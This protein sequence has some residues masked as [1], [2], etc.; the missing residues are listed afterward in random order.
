MYRKNALEGKGLK[1][2][3][4]LSIFVLITSCMQGEQ[5]LPV[6]QGATTGLV[7]PSQTSVGC[8]DPSP[9][10]P[11]VTFPS[12]GTT[13]PF[14]RITPPV[15]LRISVSN[16]NNLPY[17]QVWIV[18]GSVQATNT[19]SFI[20]DSSNTTLYPTLGLQVV[21]SAL[22]DSGGN[23][24]S[25]L[26]WSFNILSG[27][28]AY[29]SLSPLPAPNLYPGSPI[30]NWNTPQTI[31]AVV[32]NPGG[33]PYDY[34]WFLDGV[35]VFAGTNWNG[36]TF[37]YTFTPSTLALGLHTVTSL[38]TQSGTASAT[39]ATAAWSF[40][41]SN[42][43]QFT[44]FTGQQPAPAF[45]PPVPFGM[46]APSIITLAPNQLFN[47]LN[48][49]FT[50]EWTLD[51]AID[52]S[53]TYVNPAGTNGV[54]TPYIIDG[55]NRT[56]F[57]FG[58]HTVVAI[59]KDPTNA[60]IGSAAWGFTI[61]FPIPT[62]LTASIPCY[63]T[64]TTDLSCITNGLTAVSSIPLNSTIPGFF[65]LPS[66]PNSRGTAL[67][68]GTS[69]FC[70]GVANGEGIGF[71]WDPTLSGVQVQFR[72]SGGNPITPQPMEFQQ[73][74]APPNVCLDGTG[75]R[76]PLGGA[77]T[78]SL[79]LTP[80]DALNTSVSSFI[81]AR[82][83]DKL[84]LQVVA[85]LRWDITITSLNTAPVISIVSPATST[86]TIVQDATTTF[87]F[88]VTDMD[89]TAVTNFS[90]A[91]SFTSPLGAAIPL[92]G[93]NTYYPAGPP[94]PISPNCVR[95]YSY[96][97]GDKFK[98]AIIIPSNNGS[99]PVSAT[100]TYRVSADVNNLS[101]YPFGTPVSS[102][103]TNL[104][105]P[106]IPGNI[107]TWN[108]NVV[109]ANTGGPYLQNIVYSGAATPTSNSYMYLV[110]PL[111]TAVAASSASETNSIG[112]NLFVNDP[113]KDNYIVSISHNTSASPTEFTEYY[114]STPTVFTISGGAI[115]V[116]SYYLNEDV[117]SGAAF[118]TI[119][120][121]VTLTD[122]PESASPL[123][124]MYTFDLKV[125]NFNPP[126]VVATAT[127][128]PN[129]ALAA[130][131]TVMQ[132]YPYS[133]MTPN[134]TD[135]STTDSNMLVWQWMINT[136]PADCASKTAATWKSITGAEVTAPGILAGQPTEATLTWS[137]PFPS[138]SFPL[139][140]RSCFRACI[141]DTGF[142]N[143]VIPSTCQTA[144]AGVWI[145]PII[146]APA[147]IPTAAT[148]A[149]QADNGPTAIWA[150][151]ASPGNVYGAHVYRNSIF[152]VRYI[153]NANTTVTQ[154]FM[155]FPT[156]EG[157]PVT[158][159]STE[160]AYDISIIGNGNNIFVSYVFNKENGYS[161]I[162]TATVVRIPKSPLGSTATYF[163]SDDVVSSIGQVVANNVAF[164]LPYARASMN[165]TPWIMYGPDSGTGTSKAD[166]LLGTPIN[167]IQ[168]KYDGGASLYLANKLRNGILNLYKYT[169]PGSV[170]APTLDSSSLNI[171]PTSL[172]SDITLAAPLPSNQ[173]T[174]VTIK[175]V[176]QTLSY[177]RH[178][179]ADIGIHDNFDISTA[180]YPQ[181]FND[182]GI[183]SM[184]SWTNE[185]LIL[186]IIKYE[187][188]IGATETNAYLMKVTDNTVNVSK[189]I[190][191]QPGSVTKMEDSG[192]FDFTMVIP[193]F[194]QGDSGAVLGENTKPVLWF[195]YSDA[196]SERNVIVNVENETFSA[197]ATSSTDPWTLPWFSAP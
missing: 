126:P 108:I 109:E 136:N 166:L 197:S 120:F 35:Q 48:A 164:W 24:I 134:I 68:I 57:D 151:P 142:G 158:A 169:L 86:P 27:I 137:P 146:G 107:L 167:L 177:S 116:G 153:Y 54:P 93:S 106:V 159:T 21:S 7:Q 174:Y 11:E 92:N 138:V 176:N 83:T 133:F 144:M 28:P 76:F 44:T 192:D 89:G 129:L 189:R 53:F 160:K 29:S 85:D 194:T 58:N 6:T 124:N 179:E 91:Y 118:A 80:V 147:D 51:G 25:N 187:F 100:G 8:P 37:T 1:F 31:T 141:G 2:W 113:E 30:P 131:A 42:Q 23:I 196:S 173:F 10:P 60:T 18:N 88:S 70:L 117:V 171:F 105:N 50:V 40:Q 65:E 191:Q 149:L 20:I 64:S 184:A 161:G 127:Y 49:S 4:L 163:V 39:Y 34:Y 15:T 19:T 185:E 45:F 170:S 140:T 81:T 59:L 181:S 154:S 33:T 148:G 193:N 123:S 168:S 17:T 119:T 14:T 152:V 128:F 3:G 145:G 82:V 77:P 26:S 84:S 32:S 74:N 143:P 12:C 162:P 114:N 172:I 72:D 183:N 96:S 121:R 101:I 62:N 139:N 41:I 130:T 125:N 132:G 16:P 190:N 52:A 95:T 66:S 90:S 186:G 61:E 71:G 36:P 103:P 98:C 135:A 104:Y 9:I 156:Q 78:F 79:S 165:D 157:D 67:V 110:N 38:V 73:T 180:T 102:S 150:D 115:Q 122:V 188:P 75:A 13:Y 111:N 55:N 22:K 99:A 87:E 112:F 47:P 182:L 195:R 46:G 178:Q 94:S 43:P 97:A 69:S 56:K 5:K 175:D 155:E 63:S